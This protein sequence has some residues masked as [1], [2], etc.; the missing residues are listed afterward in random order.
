M[1]QLFLMLNKIRLIL[2]GLYDIYLY[3]VVQLV[4]EALPLAHIFYDYAAF[5]LTCPHTLYH[6]PNM[7]SGTKYVGRPTRYIHRSALQPHLIEVSPS[8]VELG[9]SSLGI[10][11]F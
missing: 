9:N 7:G 5:N 8:H 2:C 11:E 1:R 6:C 4:E 10:L 3:T